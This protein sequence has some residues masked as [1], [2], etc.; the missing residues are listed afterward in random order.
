MPDFS[1]Y[2]DVISAFTQCGALQ[3]FIFRGNKKTVIYYYYFKFHVFTLWSSGEY[4][5]RYK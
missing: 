1:C 4:I 5:D 2:V 3:M